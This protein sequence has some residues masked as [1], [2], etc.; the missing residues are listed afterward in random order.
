MLPA[1]PNQP[2]RPPSIARRSTE[3]RLAPEIARVGTDDERFGDTCGGR[4]DGG[5]YCTELDG[6]T[7]AP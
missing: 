2:P 7:T 1:S 3:R 4:T 6:L 5:G